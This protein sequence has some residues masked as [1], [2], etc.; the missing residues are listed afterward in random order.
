LSVHCA[1]GPGHDTDLSF[2]RR[3]SAAYAAAAVEASAANGGTVEFRGA[4]AYLWEEQFPQGSLE[5]NYRYFRGQLGCWF[6]SGESFDD[7]LYRLAYHPLELAEAIAAAISSELL[8]HC[9]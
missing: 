8:S 5:F 3:A 1:Y 7:T 4:P 2:S 9:E 6:I